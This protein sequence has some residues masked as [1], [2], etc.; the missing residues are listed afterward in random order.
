M[1][2]GSA[3]VPRAV[4]AVP[5]TTSCSLH[6]GLRLPRLRSERRSGLGRG[7]APQSWAAHHGEAPLSPSPSPFVPHGARETEAL[8]VTTVLAQSVAAIDTVSQQ[9]WDIDCEGSSRLHRGLRLP[10]LRSERRRGL[11]RGGAPQSW[12]ARHGEAPLSPSLSPFVP[13]GARETEALFVTT[14]LAQ[15]LAA[16]DTLSQQIW[17][18]DCAGSSRSHRGLRLPRLRPKRR[19][20]LG[21]GGAEFPREILGRDLSARPFSYAFTHELR[22]CCAAT[23][24]RPNG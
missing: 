5:G 14:V 22:R 17:D 24:P 13:H 12:A 8:F 2:W 21:R 19:R 23:S 11:G 20:G 16:I 1:R 4:V 15:T 10:R 18:I 7:G 3:R 9:I 6:R